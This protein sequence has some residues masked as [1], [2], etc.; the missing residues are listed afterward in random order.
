MIGNDEQRAEEEL[1]LGEL[2]RELY[3][4][5]DPSVPSAARVWNYWLGGKDNFPADRAAGER[6]RQAF[7]AIVDLA[8][9]SRAVLLRAV[10]HLVAYEGVRQFLDLGVGMPSPS[11]DDVHA[12]AQ[13]IDPSARVVHVDHD[14]LVL[15][16]ARG[17]LNGGCEGATAHCEGDLR[18]AECILRTAAQ[19]LDFAEPVAVLACHVVCHVT[20]DEQARDVVARLTAGLPEGSFLLLVD[21]V[22]SLPPDLVRAHADHILQVPFE[23][24][25]LRGPESIAR[26]LDGLELL[27]PGLVAGTAWRPETAALTPAPA[28]EPLTALCCIPAPTPP[29]PT[30]AVR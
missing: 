16:H 28:V 24:W 22:T 18:D 8:R 27:P 15:A 26:L 23:P 9:H 10:R 17:L 2:R 13:R 14:P 6:Y 21:G 7:P 20:D 3:G 19:A 1:L 5:I 12:I 11:G 29:R 30:G 4:G 25:V